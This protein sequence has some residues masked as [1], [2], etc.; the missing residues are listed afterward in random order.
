MDAIKLLIIRL[1]YGRFSHTFQNYVSSNNRHNISN[2]KYLQP[3]AKLDALNH[4]KV[5]EQPLDSLFEFTT[6]KKIEFQNTNFGVSFKH[7]L[8][9]KKR[10]SCYDIHQYQDVYWRRLGYRERIFNTGM[11]L[12]YHF[13]DNKFFFGEMFFS[14][15]SKVNIELVALSLLKKYT[16]QKTLPEKN[17]KIVGKNAFIFFENTGINLSIKYINNSDSTINDTLQRIRDYSPFAKVEVSS[18]LE[19]IL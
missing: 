4:Y 17:F 1:I 9:T 3:C 7:V 12:I 6:D 10:Y 14:D 19:D 18:D 11:R 8:R 15:S 2:Q 5:A 16:D 13:V